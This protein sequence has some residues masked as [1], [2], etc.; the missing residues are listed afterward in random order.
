MSTHDTKGAAAAAAST[1][2][3]EA[4]SLAHTAAGSGQDLYQEV[5]GGASDVVSE[6][7]GQA[8][9]LFGEA[10][11]GLTEQASEQQVRAAA[12]L[13]ALGDEFGRMADSSDEGG[14]GADL[15][16]QVAQRTGGVATWLED[17]EPGD[18]LQEV[19][20]FARRRPGV[21]LALAAGAGVLAGR[22]TRGLKD[23]PP[24]SPR[25]ASSS[26]TGAAATPAAAA[27]PTGPVPTWTEPSIT[28][29]AT[30]TV[31]GS[32]GVSG[33]ATGAGV[34]GAGAT[35]PGLTGASA[36]PEHE[37]WHAAGGSAP[38]APVSGRV[39]ASDQEGTAGGDPLA[40]VL[41]EDR[42]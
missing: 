23:A 17:R 1:A 12:S 5:K 26:P 13:R 40:G 41:R 34:T 38:V 39:P 37:A 6:A 15:V 20:D 35:G 29:P 31:T 21:F 9:D 36:H 2:K 18:V 14:L 3:D 30:P 11:T 16:R 8:R 27:T 4:S 25:T 19:A 22:V 7:A 32:T 28:E 33:G 10:R 42:P 24:A